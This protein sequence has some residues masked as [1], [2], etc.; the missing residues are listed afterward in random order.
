MRPTI[1]QYAQA[2][3]E[4]SQTTQ[5]AKVLAKNLLSFLKRRGES[6]KGALILERL[7]QLER[8]KAKQVVVTAVTAHEVSSETKKLLTKQAEGLFPGKAIEL[9]Y[10]VDPSVIGGVRFHSEETLYDATVASE[11][12]ALKKAIST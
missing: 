3:E 1:S 12:S 2:L 5:D 7:E 10:Q 9:V 4:L 6:E 11:V 8:N